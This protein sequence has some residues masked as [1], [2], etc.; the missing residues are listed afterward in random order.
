MWEVK[1]VGA[2]RRRLGVGPRLSDASCLDHQANLTFGI[3][4]SWTHDPVRRCAACTGVARCSKK[5]VR[6]GFYGCDV[7]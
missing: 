7:R 4:P 2:V 1:F 6:G 3:G 5:E